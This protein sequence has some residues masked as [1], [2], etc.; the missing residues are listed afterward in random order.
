MTRYHAVFQVQWFL[1]EE[2]FDVSSGLCWVCH[3]IC[4]FQLSH[5]SQTIDCKGGL[6]STNIF[7]LRTE[8]F[9]LVPGCCDFYFEMFV[10]KSWPGDMYKIFHDF[11]Q[12]REVMGWYVFFQL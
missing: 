10:F 2:K 4:F 12:S 11:S 7:H 5:V 6:R 9:V 8:M 3:Q 1:G